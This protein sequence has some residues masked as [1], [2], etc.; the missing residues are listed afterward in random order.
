HQVYPSQ[1]YPSGAGPSGVVPS[2]VLP[3]G[4]GDAVVDDGTWRD[5]N[6]DAVYAM[7]D[8]TC[9]TPGGCMLYQALRRPVMAG[10]TLARRGELIGLFVN[11]PA[12]REALQMELLGV[13]KS[14]AR[15]LI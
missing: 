5:L 3:L 9:S 7:V 14:N 6:M 11:D 4:P 13:G 15:G 1:D 10:Q 12:M 8:R 2:G